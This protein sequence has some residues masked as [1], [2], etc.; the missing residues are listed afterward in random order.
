MLV[1]A[2]MAERPR[3]AASR[4]SQ[5]ARPAPAQSP[6]PAAR[7][8]TA[9]VSTTQGVRRSEL[10]GWF[11]GALGC[12]TVLVVG[13]SIVFLMGQAGPAPVPPV[14]T[15][16]TVETAAAPPAGRPG[17]GTAADPATRAPAIK[18]EPMAPPAPAPAVGPTAT[19]PAKPRS[20]T[21]P[22]KVARSPSSAAK[23]SGTA[24]SADDDS[25][26]DTED[27]EPKAKPRASAAED[28]ADDR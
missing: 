26:D 9:R 2:A 25:D 23:P 18:I 14:A 8:S 19:H 22:I 1:S 24:K 7:H 15:V 20:V 3:A 13:L 28:E 12:L 17:P 16:K 6:P 5:T 27:E 21:H 11:W 10:P 4:S